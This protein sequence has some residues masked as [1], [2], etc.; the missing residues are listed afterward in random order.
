M[1]PAARPSR[2]LAAFCAGVLVACVAAGGALALISHFAYGPV[3]PVRS[4]FEAL[5]DG[6]G[7]RALSFLNAE[8][9]EG[10]GAV[11]NGKALRQASRT[12]ED[13]RYETVEKSG[14]TATVR[15]SYRIN[16]ADA[17][18]DF[19]LHRTGTWGGLFPT[20][21]IDPGELPTVKVTAP[22]T[23]AATLNQQKVGIPEGGQSFPVFY[24]GVYA[25]DYASD[26]LSA[27]EVSTAVT[28]PE[29]PTD[30]LKL[31]VE[32]SQRVEDSVKAQVGE[33]L[34]RCAEQDSLYPAG[35][36]FE[37]DFDGR[38]DGDVAWSITQYPNAGAKVKA[39]GSW[40]L[41]NPSGS[42]RVEFRKMDLYTGEVSKV[43]KTVKFTIRADLRPEGDDVVVTFR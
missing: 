9:P 6:Q 32:P 23:G 29:E 41:V 40:E 17:A 43:S 39:D 7:G 22:A 28:D 26:L 18:T 36:P 15:A 25:A 11:M 2:V 30:P 21:E 42:A 13:V 4:Y 19:S 31:A 8:V 38:V 5:Q 3:A 14:E 12:I 33:Q 37:Y 27:P 24:P 34:A 20:W 1:S 10:D 16:D 35:C